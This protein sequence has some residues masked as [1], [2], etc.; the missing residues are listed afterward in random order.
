[1]RNLTMTDTQDTQ[2]KIVCHLH[3][4]P[5]NA[6]I[7]VRAYGRQVAIF[8]TGNAVF[9]IDN[10]DPFCGAA[11][12]A[13]GIVGDLAGR[14]VV[15]SPMYKQHFCLRT[16]QCLEDAGVRVASWALCITPDERIALA[17]PSSATTYGEPS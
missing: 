6:G 16:G 4:L 5:L 10:V 2:W 3:E 15:A 13:R 12:L 7:A 1:M 8:Q 14:P 17:R 11:V 9:A